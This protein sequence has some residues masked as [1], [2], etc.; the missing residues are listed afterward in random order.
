[1]S[2][3]ARA[4]MTAAAI[5]LCGC[6]GTSNP[7]LNSSVVKPHI[8][9]PQE[10]QPGLGVPQEMVGATGEVRYCR[11]G[12]PAL[13]KARQQEAHA[14]I[15]QVCGGSEHYSVRGELMAD[16]TGSMMGVAVKCAG[17]SGR[18][19]V[20]QCKGKAGAR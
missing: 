1:M 20:F 5:A 4:S 15:E 19:I 2:F 10:K 16:A 8:Y 3:L 14:A 13:V 7:I 18:A 11:S 9:A 6:V 17:N 12:L